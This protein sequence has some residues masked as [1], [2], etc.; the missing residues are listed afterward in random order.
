MRRIRVVAGILW[1]GDTFLAAQR[2]AGKS[3]AGM[4]EFPGGKLEEGETPEAALARELQEELG[5]TPTA[6][7]FWRLVR[8]DYPDLLVELHFFHVTAFDGEPAP[9]EGHRLAWVD[10]AAATQLPFLEADKPLV[11][12]LRHGPVPYTAAPAV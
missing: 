8:H 1:R 4:W 7:R 2:P 3:M 12:D 9:L 6:V 11:H 5:V 10:W